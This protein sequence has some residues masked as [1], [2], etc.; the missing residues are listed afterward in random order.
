MAV[1]C[2]TVPSSAAKRPWRTSKKPK[3]EKR[4][5]NSS[6]GFGAERRKEP[7]WQC[8]EGCGACCKL[9]KDPAF[10]TP[11]EI[12]TDPSVV[13]MYRNQIGPDGWCIHYEKNTRKCSIYSDRPFFCR[14]EPEV[15][16]SLYGV[17]K[18]KFNKEACRCCRDAIK[19]IY[20]SNSKEL[21][22]F[23]RAIRDST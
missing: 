17:K 6:V 13:E 15:F 11:E 14:V 19:D 2:F 1:A 7:L 9:D 10:P 8:V 4:Q 20:G 22:N 3:L 21:E 18:N 23:N 5:R 12:F 16:Q